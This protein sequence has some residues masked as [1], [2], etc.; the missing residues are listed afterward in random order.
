METRE[1]LK[2]EAQEIRVADDR[3]RHSGRKWAALV[4][5][6]AVAFGVALSAGNDGA[7]GN[8]PSGQPP[9]TQLL[10]FVSEGTP[11]EGGGSVDG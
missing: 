1:A 7:T 10:P 9:V 4:A 2:E 3:R 8:D 5:A 6:V 11:I